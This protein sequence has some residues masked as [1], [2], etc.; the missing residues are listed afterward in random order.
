MCGVFILVST[1][2]PAACVVP[3]RGL[4]KTCLPERG[5]KQQLAGPMGVGDSLAAAVWWSCCSVQTSLL[6][7]I[8]L[9]VVKGICSSNQGLSINTFPFVSVIKDYVEDYK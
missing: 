1:V 7:V 9:Q 8:Y 6:I 3:V 2:G 5:D 4:K